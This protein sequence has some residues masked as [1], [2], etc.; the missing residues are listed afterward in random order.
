MKFDQ[1]QIF[2]LQI[3][4]NSYTYLFYYFLNKDI[5]C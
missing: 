1:T 2:A 5:A 4:K 3:V